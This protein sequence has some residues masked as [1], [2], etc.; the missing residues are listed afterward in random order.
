MSRV[1]TPA[2]KRARAI[3]ERHLREINLGACGTYSRDDAGQWRTPTGEL[4]PGGPLQ[5][6]LRVAFNARVQRHMERSAL[7]ARVQDGVRLLRLEECLAHVDLLLQS[8]EE[9]G[10]WIDVVPKG[11]SWELDKT[12][13]PAKARQ[14]NTRTLAGA[15]DA[16]W[17]AFDALLGPWMDERTRVKAKRDAN[18]RVYIRTQIMPS[19]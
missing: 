17:D 5:E 3:V 14:R 13:T 15:T 1:V 4:V 9:D 10:V 6:A 11:R 7:L 8:D 2:E 12:R 19:L 16:L 18:E